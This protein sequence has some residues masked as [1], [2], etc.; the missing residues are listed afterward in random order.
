MRS[1]LVPSSFF[2]TVTHVVAGSDDR[3]IVVGIFGI[4]TIGWWALLETMK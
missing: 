2:L 3:G 4:A 1:C